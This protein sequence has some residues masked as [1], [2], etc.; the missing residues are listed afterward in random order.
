MG[1]YEESKMDK[2]II[3]KSHG[4]INQ[5]QL[6]YFYM[7]Y[8]YNQDEIITIIEEYQKL[9][10]NTKGLL[11]PEDLID[12]PPFHFFHLGFYLSRFQN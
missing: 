7:T 4:L 6:D 9:N 12:F 8:N 5:A 10:L 1:C 2:A 3:E 11:N